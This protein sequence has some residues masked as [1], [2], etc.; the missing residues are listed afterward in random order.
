MHNPSEPLEGVRRAPSTARLVNMLGFLVCLLALMYALYAQMY[1]GLEPC[2]LCIFQRV[3]MLALGIAFMIAALH[4]PRGWG[5]KVYALLILLAAGAGAA[6]A[7]RQVWL[8]TL[9]A[10]QVPACGPGLDYLVETFPLAEVLNLVLKGSG[11]CA[12]IDWTF[13]GF[14]MPVWTLALFVGLGLVGAVRNWI[15]PR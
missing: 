6:V 1:L 12:K 5:G 9:P 10:D 4:E 15:G 14:S 7:G 2:P 3:A 13:L 11:E 8:Q